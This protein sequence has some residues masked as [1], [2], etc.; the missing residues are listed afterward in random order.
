MSPSPTRVASPA[1]ASLIM[2]ILNEGGGIEGFLQSIANQTVLPSEMVIVDGGSTDSTLRILRAWRPPAG[3]TLLIEELAGAGISKGRNRAI[4]LASFDRILVT[5]AGTQVEPDWAEKMLDGLNY[6][7]VASGF[8]EPLPGT[9]SSTLIATVIT[10]TI[11]EIDPEKFLPSSR[12][13]A[14]TKDAWLRGG[15]YPEWLDYCEDLI[16]DIAMKDAGV[17]FRFVPDAIVR[18]EGRPSFTAFAK[19]YFRYARGDGKAQLWARR[20]AI[21]YTAYIGGV[22][23]LALALIANPLWWLLLAAGSFAY[24]SQP[25]RRVLYFREKLGGSW[26]FALL[27]APFVVVLGDVSKMLGYPAGLSWRRKNRPVQSDAAHVAG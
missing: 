19:Q 14:F 2:T 13:I 7:D 24:M 1:P 20:H 5:D 25:F 26:P 4:E 3:V 22:M 21:R 16:F 11:K 10:P 8:F 12:S 17:S 9:F 15:K 6:A 27:L 18:W 23:L